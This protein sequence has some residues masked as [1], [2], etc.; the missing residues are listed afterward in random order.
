MFEVSETLMISHYT[1]C[2]SDSVNNSYQ[3]NSQLD[4][5]NFSE[6]DIIT[7]YIVIYLFIKRVLNEDGSSC[8]KQSTCIN[9]SHGG[10]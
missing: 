3:W 2:E 1:F 8:V 10:G 6:K 5:I 7:L 9:A 4:R